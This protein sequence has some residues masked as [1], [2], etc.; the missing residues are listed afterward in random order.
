MRTKVHVLGAAA[1]LMALGACGRPE[2]GPGGVTS[3][4]EADLDNAVAMAQDNSVF[5]VPT[6]SLV[7]N[8]EAIAAE[9]NAGAAADAAPAANGA[10]AGNRQ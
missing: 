7:A 1:M 6:D 2:T 5:E 8:E 9:E 10:Q 4:D 3:K